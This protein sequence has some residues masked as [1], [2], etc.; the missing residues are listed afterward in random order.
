MGSYSFA[1]DFLNEKSEGV[2]AH[3]QG[4]L[5]AGDLDALFDSFLA[6]RLSAPTLS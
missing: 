6:D 1:Y 5:C 3:N 4:F 2:D